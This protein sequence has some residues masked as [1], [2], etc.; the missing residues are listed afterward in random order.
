MPLKVISVV[1]GNERKEEKPSGKAL[2]WMT[3]QCQI[4]NRETILLLG[5]DKNHKGD[6][7]L[8]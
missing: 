2:R 7:G 4:S 3:T 1:I 6:S 8:R 5:Y